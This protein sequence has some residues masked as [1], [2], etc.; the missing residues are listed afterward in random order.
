MIE[1]RG[2]TIWFLSAVHVGYDGHR[3]CHVHMVQN[4]ILCLWILVPDVC[5]ESWSDIS[6]GLLVAAPSSMC[7]HLISLLVCSVCVDTLFRFS[8]NML[9]CIMAKDLH[10]GLICSETIVS[11]FNILNIILFVYYVYILVLVQF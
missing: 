9:L 4:M 11:Y 3:C 10:L 7:V 5:C 2:L 8:S 6:L 1:S